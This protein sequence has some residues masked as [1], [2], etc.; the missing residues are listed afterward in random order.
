LADEL[1]AAVDVNLFSFVLTN[2]TSP[3]SIGILKLVLTLSFLF[4]SIFV[5][6]TIFK[7]IGSEGSLLLLSFLFVLVVVVVVVA[8]AVVV[9]FSS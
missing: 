8:V 9:V 6:S 7:L 3:L 4:S 2:G 1:L 5:S